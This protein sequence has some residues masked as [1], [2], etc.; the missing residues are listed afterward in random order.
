MDGKFVVFDI[1][2]TGFSPLTCQIIEIGAVL[3]ENGQITDRFSTFVNPKV[4]IPFR[5]E[6]LTSINDSMVMDAPD[7]ETVLPQFMEFCKGAVMVAHNAD[8][9]MS[10]IIENCRRQG[11]PEE[12]TY[13]DTVGMARFLLP[14]LNRFKLD[15]VAK[16]VG[17]SLDH[18][19]RAVDDAACTAE[20]FVRFVEMLRERDIFDVDTLNDQS[21]VS[22][23]TIKKLPTYHAIILA[24]NEIGRINLY[25]LVSQSHLKYYRRR[26]RVP[27]SLFLKLREGLLIGSACEAGE[28]YQA[29]LR[30]A[31]EPE[32][33]RLVDFYDYLEIQPLGNNAFMIADEKNDRV[34]S[35]EDLIELNKKIVKLGD[36]FKKPVVATCDVHFMDPEDEIYRRIIM[37]G[38]GFSDAD[39]QA[40][41]Y[42]RTTEEM[43]EEFS[44]LGSEK[45]EEVVIT[46]TNKIADMIEKISP[47]HP[48][49]YPP[50]IAEFR[51][52]SE[53]YL[54]Y[55]S[56]RNVRQGAS[57][58]C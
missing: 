38:N 10:F 1:E 34:T 3:V 37:A 45:A 48:D 42:L 35:N 16:A 12:Y 7:I 2:T 25:K 49:K 17:V 52:G 9:D 40:P 54:F 4:P 31:P 14:A 20:I 13:V 39:N 32:I 15:T 23:N 19:H 5:I 33:A 26:P 41:L 36:Q 53:R 21:N 58:D 56:P 51:S 6:Q 24:R 47:I 27:K 44:Y 8:F 28:L 29:L 46:N 22:V 55:Q 43:M 57:E 18:H 11:L 30:N 50:V